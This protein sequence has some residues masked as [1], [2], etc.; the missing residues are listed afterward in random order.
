MEE[1]IF[2][3]RVEKALLQVDRLIAGEVGYLAASIKSVADARVGDTITSKKNGS[4][5]PLPGEHLV[6]R[7]PRRS[8]R[9]MCVHMRR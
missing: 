4:T 9:H 1:C 3:P 8:R 7:Q 5:D 2:H 6:S